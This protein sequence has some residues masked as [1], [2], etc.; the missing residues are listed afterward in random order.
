[1]TNSASHTEVFDDGAIVIERRVDVGDPQ[2]GPAPTWTGDRRRG[3]GVERDERI[4][5]RGDRRRLRGGRAVA[6]ATG[7]RGAA[8]R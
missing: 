3:G 8:R 7:A 6:G 1:M 5:D 2:L 4:G